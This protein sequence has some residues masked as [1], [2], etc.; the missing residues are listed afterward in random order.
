MGR[1][2]GLRPQAAYFCQMQDKSSQD[3]LAF[4]RSLAYQLGIEYPSMGKYLVDSLSLLD[5]LR[6]TEVR[7]WGPHI[8]GGILDSTGTWIEL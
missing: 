7:I 5:V 2:R 8:K 4:L 3:P 6:L 1:E